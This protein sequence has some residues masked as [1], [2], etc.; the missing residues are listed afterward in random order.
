MILPISVKNA[1]NNPVAFPGAFEAKNIQKKSIQNGYTE[2]TWLPPTGGNV[3]AFKVAVTRKDGVIDV[4]TGSGN[5]LIFPGIV[6]YKSVPPERVITIESHN[7]GGIYSI[8]IIEDVVKAD[9]FWP[10][11]KALIKRVFSIFKA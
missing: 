8:T 3:N 1:A 7:T 4:I 6:K 11:L 9:G 5:N 10:K 2:I